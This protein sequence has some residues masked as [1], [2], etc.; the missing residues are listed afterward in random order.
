MKTLQTRN[1]FQII[2]LLLTGLVPAAWADTASYTT[3][4]NFTWTCPAGVTSVQVECWGGGGA[5]GG[6]RKT[7][8]PGA[9]GG[10]GG[11]G[12]YAKATS[13]T[14]T[15][16][17]DYTVVVG[18]GGLHT[19]T[20]TVTGTAAS[21]TNSWFGLPSASTT[22]CLAVGGG[23]GQDLYGNTG[24]TGGTGGA[25]GSCTYSG[26]GSVAYSGGT[27]ATATASRGGG[28]GSSAGTSSGGN[29]GGSGAV[30][31]AGAAVTGGGAGGAGTI[32]GAGSSGGA[33]G[34]GGGGAQYSASSATRT[35]GDGAAGQ[36]IL[37]YTVVYDH[38][39]VETAA[40]G[41]GS[42]VSAQ[43][44]SSGSSITVYA[45]GRGADNSFMSNAPAAWSLVNKTGGVATSDLVASGDGT[46]ATFTGH[47]SGSANIQAV[48]G[49]ATANT[50]GLITVPATVVTGKLW[51]V[52]ADGNWSAAG[53]WSGG[54][55][56]AA[57]DMAILGVGSSL[58]TVT[59][60]TGE[61]VGG[62]TFTNPNSFVISG[63]NT[64]TLDNSGNGAALL[65]T[66][67]TT[68][69]IKTP[70]ALNDNTAITVNSGK[71]LIV[72]GTIANTGAA[73]TL[74]VGDAG[75]AV[76]SSANTYGPASSG[77]TG[78]TLNGGGT[79]QI[80][81]N[82]SLGAGDVS[83]S[84]AGGTIQ[85]GAAGLSLTNNI[86][87]ASGTTAMLDNQGN[88]FTLGGI[89]S[90]TAGN[91]AATGNGTVVLSGTNTYTGGTTISGG[92]VQFSADNNLGAS[93]SGITLNGGTLAMSDSV[94]LYLAGSH[95]ITVGA[96]GGTINN[97][98]T[99]ADY[100]L[101]AAGQLTGSGA[102]TNTG[103]F[104]I[105]IQQA[106][107][108]FTGNLYVNGGVTEAGVANALGSSA[109]TVNP[110]GELAVDNATLANSLTVN[111]GT[112][113][114]NN[115]GATFSGAIS[116][117]AGGMTV[118]NR[119][120]WQP[121]TTQPATISGVI[122]GGGALTKTG[123]G[124]LT[125]NNANSYSGGTTNSAG[126][127]IIANGTGAGSGTI[128]L[129]NGATLG[130]PGGSGSLY[131][132]NAVTISGTNATAYL[133][134]GQLAFQFT[135]AFSGSSDQTL[136]MSGST[137][138]NLGA[139][140]SKQLQNMYGTVSI[141]SGTTLAFRATALTNGSDNALFKVDGYLTTRNGGT[142]ALGALSGSGSVSMGTSGNNGVGLAYTIGA[143]GTDETFS[144]VISD[145][146]T[147]NNKRVSV[148]KT[149]S[150][151]QTFSG[152]NT[153]TGNTTISNG[154]LALVGTASIANSANLDISAGAQLDVSGLSGAFSLGGQTLKGNGSVNGSVTVAAGSTIA[155]GESAVGTLTVSNSV[156]L[157]GTTWMTVNTNSAPN[158][159]Q[160]VAGGTLAFGGTLVISNAGPALAVGNQF[161]L[162][163][164]G[165][166]GSFTI[167]PASP[168]AGLAWDTSALASSGILKVASAGPSGTD[169]LTNSVAG[170]TLSLSWGLGWTLECQ[171][172]SLTVGL[173][174]NWETCVPSSAN[175]TSTNITVDPNSP[176]VFYR[177]TYP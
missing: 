73:R 157:A 56:T 92:T 145:G 18:G 100:A 169:H 112:I 49:T 76:L 31:N 89:I 60:D 69:A 19:P 62:I 88:T 108:G 161:T 1:L 93:A 121:A 113:S 115:G 50:S 64:L 11:G 164:A 167:S 165:G 104:A 70:V 53:N 139:I 63:A 86:S 90:G 23:G 81:N 102:L 46:S 136:A 44:V 68:N 61:S 130:L 14:V 65:V 47:Q 111:G 66:G 85:A 17:T 156:T 152:A 48:V 117:G 45:I 151:T 126:T 24:G 143:R 27:G 41:S 159:S 103:V 55:P 137:G 15:P 40:D 87:I 2:C 129:E 160:L 29:N 146:D 35:G 110:G 7:A 118:A 163:S 43:D 59:L 22:N 168:G 28:G 67:G 125:L 16:G 58:R 84:G 32:G 37:T 6:A 132:G 21:G 3:A 83:V 147:A 120:W 13:I 116:I 36:V 119:N 101:P 71:T 124:T 134:S 138:V 38:V 135:G 34:G 72:S 99:N 97:A 162:F 96:G 33:P 74:T 8:S 42:I 95:T 123:G 155:P 142:V 177:L 153:Y 106:N 9:G 122:S 171:T 127:L 5:G 75:T 30:N 52:D 133:T 51:N 107:S 91:L 175:I 144:G 166:T 105:W 148:T 114:P 78:T 170:S 176:A 141:P 54:V 10:G 12:A 57:G 172:N 174:T 25:A 4:G 94:I 158:A 150:G 77:T 140:S 173:G 26:T 149:G 79:L 128:T 98:S 39:N 109:V 154:V 131:V 82:T 80:G 20:F